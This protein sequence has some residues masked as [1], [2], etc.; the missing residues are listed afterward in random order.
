MPRMTPL[1]SRIG[2]LCR[3]N[4]WEEWSGFLTATMY[5]L[6]HLHEY[7][8]IRTG[9]ALFDVSPLLKYDIRGRDAVALVDAVGQL[10]VI[11]D[12]VQGFRIA[13]QSDMPDAG[14]GH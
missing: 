11:F 1:H 14:R 8:A 10:Q 13:V 7:N 6:D 12:G 9:C 5:D 2:P 4:R 3:G